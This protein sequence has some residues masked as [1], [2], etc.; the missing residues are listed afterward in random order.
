[1]PPPDLIELFVQPLNRF[2]I[3]YLVSGSVGTM[4]D[5]EPRVTHD[6]DRVVFLRPENM[7]QLQ[8]AFPTPDF[9]LPPPSVIAVEMARERRGHFNV[10]HPASGLKAD[11]YI[12]RRDELHAWA[13]RHVRQ[14]TV[15]NTHIRLAPPE[16]VIV[17]K[18]EYLCEGGSEKHLRDIRGILAVSG[19]RLDRRALHQWIVRRG[20]ERE[21]R[22]VPS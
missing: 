17:R 19:E 12:A 4:L 21:W 20:L 11:F 3:R 6:I 1:M 14:Y 2:G 15:G 7:G 9:Y 5:G 10:L 13:F 22:N 8:E 18:L 16:Y